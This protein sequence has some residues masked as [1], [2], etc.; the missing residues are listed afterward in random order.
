MAHLSQNQDG[1]EPTPGEGP[2]SAFAAVRIATHASED[3]AAFRDRVMDVWATTFDLVRDVEDWRSTIWERHRARED[4]R[5]VT[6]ESD[7]VLVGFAW[8]YTGRPG[9]FWSDFVLRTLGAAAAPWVGGHLEFVELA[10]DPGSQGR[11]IGGLLHDAMLEGL[12]HDRALLGTT[13]DADAPTYSLYRS[14][15]WQV[16]GS[17]APGDVVMGKRLT[18]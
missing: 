11:G 16:I 17:Q 1:A 13:D 10:V 9:Q 18:R 2:G 7:G 6:A 8:G 12:P 14:R 5:L 15:G 4:Y 3:A